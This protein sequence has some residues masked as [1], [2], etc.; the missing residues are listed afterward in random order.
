MYHRGAE[1][2]VFVLSLV[3][4][5]LPAEYLSWQVF[6]SS[7]PTSRNSIHNLT[8]CR[9][10]EGNCGSVFDP[11]HNAVACLTRA[12]IDSN[13]LEIDNLTVNAMRVLHL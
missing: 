13:K 1:E 8:C 2:G 4:F 9:G 12:F 10:A 7:S 5:S 6:S 3:S 11:P